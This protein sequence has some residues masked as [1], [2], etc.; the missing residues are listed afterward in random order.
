MIFKKIIKGE[1]LEFDIFSLKK[2]DKIS[3]YRLVTKRINH[4]IYKKIQR[5][6]LNPKLRNV[7]KK[8][9]IIFFKKNYKNIQLYNDYLIKKK[10]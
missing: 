9:E 4:L 10:K 1:V 5:V 8:L 7:L 3:L 6:I 2:R